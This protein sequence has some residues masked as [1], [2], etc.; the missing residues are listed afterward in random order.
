MLNFVVHVDRL[1]GPGMTLFTTIN[2]GLQRSTSLTGQTTLKKTNR[3]K[4]S[5]PSTRENMNKE[6]RVERL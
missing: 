3:K 6:Q 2:S 1:E 5:A 4:Q